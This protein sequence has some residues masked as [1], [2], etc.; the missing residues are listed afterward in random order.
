MEAAS[1]SSRDFFELLLEW[2]AMDISIDPEGWLVPLPLF[3]LVL[4]HA[5]D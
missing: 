2:S 1:H 3:D 5:Q 4:W